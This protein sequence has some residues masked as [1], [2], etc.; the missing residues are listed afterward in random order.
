MDQELL[1]F[2]TVVDKENFSLAAKELHITQPA[3]SRYIKVLENK[4]NSKLLER[5]NKMVRVTRAGEIVYHHAKEILSL[6]DRMESLVEGMMSIP[7]GKLSIGASYTFGEYILPHVIA[8]L[9]RSFPLINPSIS[10]GNTSEIIQQVTARQLDVGII[11][12]KIKNDN[13]FKE[14]FSIDTMVVVVSAFHPIA[15]QEEVLL[16]ELE[17]ETWIVREPGSGTREVTDE[18]FE[19]YRFKPESVMEFGS[20]Q[21]IKE[22]VE[23]GLGVSFLSSWTIRKELALGTIKVLNIKGFPIRRNFT[24]VKQD[25]LFQTKAM[26]VFIDILHNKIN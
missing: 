16:S 19:D 8:N 25:T 15:N 17:Q 9:R 18:M 12:G 2:K 10:I 4:M 1:V 6:Y 3:V 13:M 20:T 21:I 22:S 23:A 24:L 14:R 11:E 26:E 5:N 7:A